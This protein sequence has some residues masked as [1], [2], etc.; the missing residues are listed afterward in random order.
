MGKRDSSHCDAQ[1]RGKIRDYYICQAC[2]SRVSLEGHHII[3]YQ[4][5][6]SADADNIITLCHSCHRK[7]HSGK[8]NIIK[9]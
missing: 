9:F 5:G 4:F 2:G 1:R 3:D 6:G 8:L 7:V